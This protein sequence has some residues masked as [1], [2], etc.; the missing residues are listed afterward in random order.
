MY[1]I[2][3]CHKY[4]TRNKMNKTLGR[5]WI[6]DVQEYND[7]I[8]CEYL[9]YKKGVPKNT[10]KGISADCKAIAKYLS[11]NNA[12]ITSLSGTASSEQFVSY[13]TEKY[14]PATVKRRLCT[15]RSIIYWCQEQGIYP[16]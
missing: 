8:I 10:Y 3:V 5:R 11:D 16:Y 9:A 6:M 14:T 1:E 7:Q 15:L 2:K 12:M 4:Y 13:L